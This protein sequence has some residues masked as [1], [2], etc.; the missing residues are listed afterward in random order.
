MPMNHSRM[1]MTGTQDPSL[2]DILLKH[3]KLSVGIVVGFAA[4]AA[5]IT[6]MLPKRYT[7]QMKVLVKNERAEPTITP[8]EASAPPTRTELTEARVN[9]EVEMLQSRDLLQAVVRDT[10]LYRPYLEGGKTQPDAAV[11]DTAVREFRKRLR[12]EPIRKSDIIRVSYEAPDPEL[13]ARVLET[14]SDRYLSAHL[15]V[16][17]SARAYAFFADETSKYKEELTQAQAAA[18]S[19]RRSNDLFDV[20]IQ[21]TATVN[22]LQDIRARLSD[23]TASLKETQ[24]RLTALQRARSQHSERISTQQRTVVNASAVGALEM[25]AA[26]LENQRL[27]LLVKYKPTDRLV[28]ETERELANVKNHLAAVRGEPSPENTTDVN[29]LYQSLTADLTQ[30]EV[31]LQRL[32]AREQAL[33]QE[34]ATYVSALARMDQS[35]VQLSNLEQVETEAKNNYALYTQRLE[36]A[37]LA[38]QMDRSKVANVE[39]IETPAPSTIPTFPS[40]PLNVALGIFGGLC[41]AAL[42]SYMAERSGGLRA[43]RT[44]D[45]RDRGMLPNLQ[46][47]PASGD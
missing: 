31:E 16:H 36:Q 21:R 37:R 8:Q 45:V 15:A 40:M 7:S 46:S 3:W 39:L 18:S 32:R 38:D 5:L 6:T 44:L 42:A 24:T 26:E 17:S 30:T 20:T 2:V 27:A 47:A 19:F 1:Y 12:V 34:E 4:L 9:S 29:P 11:L 33:R 25:K 14:L 13:A 10:Q 28:Q 41:C 35:A 22:R 43:E 23:L